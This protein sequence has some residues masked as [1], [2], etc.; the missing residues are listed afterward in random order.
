MPLNT[1]LFDNDALVFKN[2]QIE[3]VKLCSRS[4]KTQII[5]N[6]KNWPYFGIWTKKGSDAFVCLEPWYGIADSVDAKGDISTKEG[7]QLLKSYCT[8]KA[9]FSIEIAN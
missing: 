1:D 6:C 2:K 7:I 5:L 4:S 9:G 3:K 8:F